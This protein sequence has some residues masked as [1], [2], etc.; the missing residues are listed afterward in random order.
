MFD[1][2]FFFHLFPIM[3][4]Y[5]GVTLGISLA[6]LVLSLIIAIVIATAYYLN[7]P[8]L[9]GLC[10]VWVSVFRGT[11]L[12]AQLFWLCY[13]LPQLIVPLQRVSVMTLIVWGVAFNASSYMSETLRGALS[14]VNK[15]QM[16]ASLACGMT[17]MQ[18]FWHIVFPQAAR[19][20][21]PGLS[22]NFVDIIKQSSLAFTLG[23]T[24][25]MA[26]ARMEGSTNLKFLESF[27]AVMV[28]Y[29]LIVTFFNYVQK[30]LEK[31]LSRMY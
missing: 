5:I 3:F 13:G 15:G 12:L 7:I 9:R 28:V 8:L 24:E 29:W 6:S 18:G 21:V 27:T 31:W 16:E 4:R 10:A 19:V 30:L 1:T 14:S 22:N 23:V 11:P 25:I 20:A 2:S 17:R 26:V